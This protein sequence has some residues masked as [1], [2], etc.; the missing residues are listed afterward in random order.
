MLIADEAHTVLTEKYSDL[1]R[2]N[3]FDY[4]LGLTG[5][6]GIDI[7]GKNALYEEFA[8]IIY[9]YNDSAKDGLINKT[10]LFIFEREL[11]NKFKVQSGSKAKPFMQGEYDRY[12]YLTKQIKKGQQLMMA[13]N[14][15]DF[16]KDA[17]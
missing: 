15:T 4:I 1:L 5:T 17:A 7:E 9:E 10:R 14:S 3:E 6:S 11:D 16:W 8:P 12:E 13:Q 2:N